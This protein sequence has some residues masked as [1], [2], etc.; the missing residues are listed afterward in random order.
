M[1]LAACE[2]LEGAGFAHYEISNWAAPDRES[3]HNLAY[4]KNQPYLGLGPGAHSSLLGKRW[5]V[6]KSP[7]AYVDAVSR[8][9][10][11]DDGGI[12]SW[13]KSAEGSGLVRWR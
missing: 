1:Y 7:R 11:D 3:A 2:T 5:A 10:S 13:I 6:M 8:T 9:S 12:E 4:W